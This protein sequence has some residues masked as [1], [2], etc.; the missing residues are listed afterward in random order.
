MTVSVARARSP[1]KD[2][3]PAQRQPI[4]CNGLET[5]KPLTAEQLGAFHM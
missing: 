3:W 5:K 1:R 4:R 2:A